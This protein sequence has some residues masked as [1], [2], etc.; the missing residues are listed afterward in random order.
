MMSLHLSALKL[1]LLQQGALHPQAWLAISQCV[2]AVPV[3]PNEGIRLETGSLYYVA[4][5]LL[6]EYDTLQRSQPRI[7][8]F[9]SYNTCFYI[10]IFNQNHY[11]KAIQP[12]LILVFE[13]A[14]LKEIYKFHKELKIMYDNLKYQYIQQLNLRTLIIELPVPQ[15]LQQ[16]K[17]HFAPSVNYLKKK[18]VAAYLNVSYN[19][20]IANW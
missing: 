18:D 7:V 8:N 2:K 15:R 16:F 13:M 5:D 10:D 1:F 9:I 4:Q 11:F 14:Q 12:S 17:H 3:K 19:Y 6:K 20:L